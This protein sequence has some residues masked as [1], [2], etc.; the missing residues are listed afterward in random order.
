MP[1]GEHLK[2]KGGVKFG[3]GQPT[4]RGGRPKKIYTILKEKGFNNDDVKAC[5]G[6]MAFYTPAEID[7]VLSDNTKPVIMQ[8]VAA[9]FS[10]AISE[11]NW[12]KIK[13]II[14]HVIGKPVQRNE[15]TAKDGDA[16]DFSANIN[17][18]I[19]GQGVAEPLT[20]EDEVRKKYNLDKGS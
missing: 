2:G 16:L 13:E 19:S 7:D 20:S 17:L 9:A 12:S 5:F 1:K 15:L 10:A 14:E 6:E 18:N 4:D 8:V 11:G 3:E